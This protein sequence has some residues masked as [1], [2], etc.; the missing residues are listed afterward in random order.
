MTPRSSRV[1][2]PRS[3]LR[4]WT[5]IP[6]RRR[7]RRLRPGLSRSGPLRGRAGSKTAEPRAS[8]LARDL[9]DDLGRLDDADGL[10]AHLELQVIDRLGRH[11]TDEAVRAGEN[12]D[13]GHHP[14]ALDP[15]DDPGEPVTGRLGDDRSVWRRA[16]PL[17]QQPAY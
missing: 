13:D 12:L 7:G 3:N 5:Q 17:R 16:T 15:G 10:R 11:E 2:V 9:D 1:P 4:R 14:I 6:S 8:L